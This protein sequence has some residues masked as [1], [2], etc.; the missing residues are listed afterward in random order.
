MKMKKLAIMRMLELVMNTANYQL[1][2]P[3]SLRLL[4]MQ[5]RMVNLYV[6]FMESQLAKIKIIAGQALRALKNHLEDMR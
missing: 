2:L 5:K 3:C 4:L 6:I 1:A